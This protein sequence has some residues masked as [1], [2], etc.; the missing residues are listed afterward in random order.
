M[1]QLNN[2]QRTQTG[3]YTCTTT[4]VVGTA[5]ADITLTVQCEWKGRG[6]EE[7]GEEG[8]EG[9]CVIQGECEV[10][11]GDIHGLILELTPSHHTHMYMCI[12][13]M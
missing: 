13:V 7:R 10:S 5:S 2:V 9:S 1:L 4:N 6:G 12:R 8:R 3:V 11:Q